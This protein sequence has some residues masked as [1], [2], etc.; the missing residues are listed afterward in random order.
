MVNDPECILIKT[1]IYD[2]WHITND[3]LKARDSQ[4]HICF[5]PTF[6]FLPIFILFMVNSFLPSQ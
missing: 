2:M 4:D 5:S 6:F 3:K 1:Y